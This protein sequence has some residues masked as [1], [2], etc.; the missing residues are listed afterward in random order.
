MIRES[1]KNIPT[2]RQAAEHFLLKHFRCTLNDE[3]LDAVKFESFAADSI[4]CGHGTEMTKA[5]ILYYGEAYRTISRSRL[6]ARNLDNEAFRIRRFGKGDILNNI[7][8]R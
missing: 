5:L 2:T 7:E 6:T 4:L 3:I 1:K 8:L